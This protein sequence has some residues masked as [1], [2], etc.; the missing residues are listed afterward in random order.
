MA[1]FVPPAQ[2]GLL[3]SLVGEE[4]QLLLDSLLISL[5]VRTCPGAERSLLRLREAAAPVA[6]PPSHHGQAGHVPPGARSHKTLNPKSV[7]LN[8][9]HGP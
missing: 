2:F 8:W 5:S 9:I 6:A 4:S 3:T 7:T 1:S